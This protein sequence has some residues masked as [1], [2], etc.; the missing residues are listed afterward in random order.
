M[1]A[2]PKWV[3]IAAAVVGL[4]LL[5]KLTLFRSKAVLVQAAK[6]EVG[7]VEETVSNTRAGTVK[8][9]ERSRLSPQIGGRVAALPFAKGDRVPV[10]GLL[11]KLDD[12]VQSAQLQLAKDQQRTAEAKAQEACL[13]ADL[14]QKE[15]QRGLALEKDGIT[16]QQALDQLKSDRDR[17]KAACA[18]ARAALQE[19]KAQIRMAQAELDLTEV[20]APFAGVLADCTTHVGEWI[21]PSPPGV[22]IPPVLDL[23]SP[24]STYVSAPV[25][26]VDSTRVRPGLT[27]R[28]T[29]DSRPGERFMGKVSRVAPYVVDLQDMNRT[30]EVEATF[31]DPA[32]AST[33]LPGTSADVEIILNRLENV[34]RVPTAAIAE[35]GKVL[36]VDSGRLRE[37]TVTPGLKNWQFTQVLSGL[38][39]GDMVVTARDSA[40]IRPGARAEIRVGP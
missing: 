8:V 29:I 22:P 28:I 24:D 13:A 40:E 9:R 19:A 38:A 11:L 37:R 3:W 20:R 31:D 26:E 14:A 36:V 35:G 10:G 6:V 23:L 17:S 4:A 1:R 33:I 7:V 5:L 32:Q 34:L 39:A 18:A 12:S 21:T 16:S 25:D 15:W 2:F 30:V 27:A